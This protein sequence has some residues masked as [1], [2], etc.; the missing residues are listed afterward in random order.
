MKNRRPA[1]LT[2]SVVGP[3]RVLNKDAV[4]LYEL[5][6]S[7]CNRRFAIHQLERKVIA[8]SLS[9]ARVRFTSVLRLVLSF[10]A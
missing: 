8:G 10:I 9:T 5:E 3:N 1:E 4:E 6:C 7:V 2:M